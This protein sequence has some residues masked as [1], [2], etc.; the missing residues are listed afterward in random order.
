MIVSK[1]RK[2]LLRL[3]DNN[4]I[5]KVK[6]NIDREKRAKL[7]INYVNTAYFNKSPSPG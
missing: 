2:G 6:L 7:T 4:S 3:I 5:K 1:R